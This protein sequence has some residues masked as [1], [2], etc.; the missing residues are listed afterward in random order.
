MCKKILLIILLLAGTHIGL[1]AE[2]QEQKVVNINLAEAIQKDAKDINLSEIASDIDYIG[3]ETTDD[4]LCGNSYDIRFFEEGI[5]MGTNRQFFHFDPHGKF[6]NAIGSKGEG[7][8]EYNIGLLYFLDSPKKRLYAQDFQEVICYSFDGEF[9]KRIST[10]NLNMGDAAIFGN[11]LIIYS[12]DTYFSN[13]N[14]PYQLFIINE[15]G[16]QKKAIKGHIEKGKR[17]GVILSSRDYIY[18]F[19]D[20]TYFKPA[21]ENVI[22]KIDSSSMKKEL[23]Y[24]FECGTKDI[25]VSSNETELRNRN[26]SISI[27]Q[28]HETPMHLFILY[29]LEKRICLGMYDKQKKSFSN[30]RIVDDLSGGIDFVPAGKCCSGYLQMVYFPSEFKKRKAS[31]R[32]SLPEKRKQFEHVLQLDEE[33]NPVVVVVKLKGF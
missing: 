19:D 8:E 18:T 17:Y 14:A 30:V 28:I 13:K 1:Y 7:P 25:D 12:N 9:I 23:V 27:Y 5:I 21:L 2:R 24:K 10:P 6:L 20:E 4:A 32:F 15:A 33:D 22:Y 31:N 26:K 29:G 16:K 3:L 11:G